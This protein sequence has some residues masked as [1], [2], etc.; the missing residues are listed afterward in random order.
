MLFLS[1]YD[2][3]YCYIVVLYVKKTVNF[4]LN[5]SFIALKRDIEVDWAIL[6]IPGIIWYTLGA[7]STIIRGNFVIYVRGTI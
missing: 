1:F 6:N 7:M 3:L 4:I 5:P 2:V